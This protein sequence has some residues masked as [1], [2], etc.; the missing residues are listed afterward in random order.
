VYIKMRLRFFMVFVVFLAIFALSGISFASEF[1]ADL[2]MKGS[3]MS[4]KGKVWVKGQKMRQEFGGQ[5]GGI[6][7]IMDLDKGFS[8]VLMPANK[9]YIKSKTNTKGKGFSPDNFVG[10]QQGQ[11]AAQVKRVGTETVDGYKCDKYLITYKN[12]QMGSMT[13]WF[14]KKL[15]YPI[16]MINKNSMAGD[17]TSQLE[18]IKKGN[19]KDS[20][21]KLPSG[22]KEMKQPQ[23]PGMPVKE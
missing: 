11:M 22:Y 18:N 7:T 15:N 17:F 16:K 6:I 20:L 10:M 4:G 2:I 19:V 3:A 21:F 23:I 14:A 9:S 8:W 1:S 13:Q 12:K 5:M